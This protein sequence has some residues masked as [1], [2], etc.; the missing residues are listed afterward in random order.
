MESDQDD[1][2]LLKLMEWEKNGG[3]APL[4]TLQIE[5]IS[6]LTELAS[7]H[8]EEPSK[9]SKVSKNGIGYVLIWKGPARVSTVFLQSTGHFYSL[10][11]SFLKL[12]MI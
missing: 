1:T 6:D 11:S 5:A 4:S 2:V 3:L 10:F 12:F 9:E 8:Q 7:E